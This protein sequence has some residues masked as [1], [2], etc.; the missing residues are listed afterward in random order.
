MVSMTIGGMSLP[1]LPEKIEVNQRSQNASYTLMDIGE[2][3]LI[4]TPKQR[5]LRVSSF[6]PGENDAFRDGAAAPGAYVGKITEFFNAKKPVGFVVKGI[7]CGLSLSVTIE[8]FSY[9]EQAGDTGTVYFTL[10]LKEYRAFGAQKSSAESIK[11]RESGFAGP[12]TYKVQSGDTLWAIAK[13]L[14]GDGSRYTEI[15]KLND[16]ENP[17]LIY[18]G[19]VLRL[20]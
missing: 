6:F 20:P 1:V 19:R 8:S 4:K 15:V 7:A 9:Y 18:P 12:K 3:T 2:I 10:D 13:R 16:I 14:L 5:E 11:T 17:N